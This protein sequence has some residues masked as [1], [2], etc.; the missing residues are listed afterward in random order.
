MHACVLV[1]HTYG[2]ALSKL[3]EVKQN[4]SGVFL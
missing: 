4:I 3:Q 1:M 2:P